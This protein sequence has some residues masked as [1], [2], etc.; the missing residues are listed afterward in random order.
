MKFH[1]N[2]L[3]SDSTGCRDTLRLE[4]VTVCHADDAIIVRVNITGS[5]SF[6]MI[7]PEGDVGE[8]TLHP[9]VIELKSLS[10]I[11]SCHRVSAEISSIFQLSITDLIVSYYDFFETTEKQWKFQWNQLAPV[12]LHIDDSITQPSVS[13]QGGTS[14]HIMCFIIHYFYSVSPVIHLLIQTM[15]IS[16]IK[17]FW[18][19]FFEKNFLLTGC[20]SIHW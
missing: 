4:L 20:S 1:W 2:Y 16:L 19:E 15:S 9:C 8:H 10:S 11:Y 5:R 17:I 12:P 6:R 7:I 3:P 14:T 13:K 18:K